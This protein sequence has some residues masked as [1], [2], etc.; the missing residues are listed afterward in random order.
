MLS[1]LPS[2]EQL[3]IG[4]I[5]IV[6]LSVLSVRVRALDVPGAL[7]GALISLAS[8]FAG[9]LSWLAIIIVFVLTGSLLTRFRYEY[10]LKLGTAQEKGG[11]RSWSN[12]VANGLIG[13]LFAVAEIVSHQPIFAIAYL[14]SISAAMSDTIAT[15]IG[16]LSSSKPRLIY[17]PRKVVAAGVSGGVSGLGELAGLISALGLGVFGIAIG[18]ISGQ[19]SYV[20][21]ALASVVIASF[22][23]MNCDSLL[24]ATVQGMNRCVVCN[25]TTESLRHHGK[26]TVTVKGIRYLENNMVNLI[27]TVVAAALG[28]AIYLVLVS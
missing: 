28:V 1:L 3:I 27:S 8:L 2:S 5:I 21:P 13:G 4:A 16:L 17:N 18:V 26:S 23:A 10:K 11:R 22:I 12:A 25:E 7:T 19:S 15:E 9:G 6:A 24:G 14:A 20:W